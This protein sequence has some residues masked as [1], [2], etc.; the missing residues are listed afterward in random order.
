M[1]KP[2]FSSTL[3]IR[4]GDFPPKNRSLRQTASYRS[5]QLDFLGQALWAQKRW[6]EAEAVCRQ[7]L[8]EYPDNVLAYIGLVWV[9]YNRGE[10]LEAS[11]GTFGKE[12]ETKQ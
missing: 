2:L 12:K 4:Q 10:G 7:I 5:D 9:Y 6:D 1:E 8:V 3:R 11:L